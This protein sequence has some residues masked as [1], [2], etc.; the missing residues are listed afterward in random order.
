[1]ANPKTLKPFPKG[2]SGNPAGRPPD[3]PE[4]KEIQR[5]TKGS[6]ELLV[7]KILSAKPEELNQFRGT[8]LEVWLASGA[9][10][11]IKAGDY[12]RLVTLLERLIGK[13]PVTIDIS[14]DEK[15][16][17]QEYRRR[18]ALGAIAASTG[19]IERDADE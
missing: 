11:A 2:V 9:S 14:D 18:R 13:V 16:L 3:P 8:V 19:V 7:N 6:L 17:I 15:A 4:L 5:L 1:M 12:Q 10:Q